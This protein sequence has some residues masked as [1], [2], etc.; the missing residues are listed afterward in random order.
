MK[1]QETVITPPKGWV[2][3]DIP[4]LWKFRE[5]A[6]FFV[7]RDIKVRYKQTFVGAA[8]AVFQPMATMIVFTMFF[9]RLI[10]VPS[11]GVPYPLFVYA[12]LLFWNYF[13]FALSHAANSMIENSNII[14][15]IYFPRLIIPIASS[16]TGMVDFFFASF[17]FAA[18]LVWYRILPD[19]WSV[20]MVPVLLLIT[21]LTS[22]G[23]GCLLAGLNVKYRDIRYILP[24]FLQ[25]LLFL[26]PVIYP[27][28]IVHGSARWWLALN[29][30]TSVIEMGRA[31][32]V[33]TPAPEPMTLVSSLGVGILLF[34]IGIMYFRKTERFFADII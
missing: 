4:E 21:F 16:L 7:W 13:S 17:A 19:P 6:Y 15:K 27:T 14:K 25:L 29:P 2:Q 28:S 18:L 9:G 20:V 12:G 31:M 3:L 26:T 10:K 8:W 22:V 5:L 1:V 30:M 11:D 32:L 34:L 33:G 23:M 24:F